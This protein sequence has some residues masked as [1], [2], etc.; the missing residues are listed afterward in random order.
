MSAVSDDTMRLLALTA[1]LAGCGSGGDASH[2]A[3]SVSSPHEFESDLPTFQA[4]GESP[5]KM[6][7]T[8]SV[9]SQES[10]LVEAA[11][12]DPKE[13]YPDPVASLTATELFQE[14]E[15]DSDAW[16]KK[17]RYKAVEVQGKVVSYDSRNYAFKLEL[18]TGSRILPVV[19]SDETPWL[20]YPPNTTVTIR[21]EAKLPGYP[22]IDAA[23]VIGSEPGDPLKEYAAQEAVEAVAK[24]DSGA[25]W[26]LVKGSVTRRGKDEELKRQL[27]YIGEGDKDFVAALADDNYDSLQCRNL[28]AGAEVIFL[29]KCRDFFVGDDLPLL[30]PSFLVSP[31]PKLPAEPKAENRIGLD[32]NP[33]PHLIFSAELLGEWQLESR[34]LKRM[35]ERRSEYSEVEITGEVLEIKP[36]GKSDEVYIELKNS[37]QTNVRAV[38]DKDDDIL[39]KIQP[40]SP[41]SV[42]GRLS[43]DPRHAYV[44]DGKIT[45]K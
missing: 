4:E 42:Q 19:V 39:S 43:V 21:G 6:D 10:E 16:Q 28:K 7:V 9:A 20:K 17:Y 41:I 38:V 11:S 24:D 5:P 22:E 36:S 33:S 23:V 29:A 26:M 27:I 15:Q 1:V 2:S 18:E 40:G 44:H 8:E 25:E 32:G 14:F 3:A 35:A 37:S 30:H 45:I 31:L 13:V 34:A 12:P